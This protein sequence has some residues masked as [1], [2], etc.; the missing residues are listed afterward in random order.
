MVIECKAYIPLRRKTIRV[1]SLRWLRPPAPQFRIGDTNMLA[2]KNAKICLTPNAKPKIC[3]TPNANPPRE[4]V[5]YRLHGVPNAKFLRWPCTFLFFCVE[6]IRVWSRFS[7][8]YGL[9]VY[10]H[11]RLTLSICTLW[12]SSDYS[13]KGYQTDPGWSGI[14]LLSG[15]RSIFV[16]LLSDWGEDWI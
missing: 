12:Q 2:S 13:A 4:S 6:F 15:N 14:I 5:E 11:A 10:L 9:N 3:V 7:V 1:R 8:A 16:Y